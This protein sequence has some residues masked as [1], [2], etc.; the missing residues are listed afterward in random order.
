MAT[1]PEAR[2]PGQASEAG[3]QRRLQ[4]ESPETG[5][6]H[7]RTAHLPHGLFLVGQGVGVWAGGGLHCLFLQRST[8]STWNVAMALA[9]PETAGSGRGSGPRRRNSPPALV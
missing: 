1:L 2:R 4:P 3:S 8:V 9:S 6:N 5:G 7:G